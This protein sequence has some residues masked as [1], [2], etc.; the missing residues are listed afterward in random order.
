MITAES[1]GSKEY[2]KRHN[3]NYAYATGGMYRGIASKELVVAM[4]RAGF[5]SYFGSGGLKIS[6]IEEAILE[7]KGR[8]TYD[9]PF[10]INLLHNHIVSENEDRIID[11][12]LKYRVR[13]VEL[14]AFTNITPALVYY[15]LNGICEN[16]NGEIYTPNKICAKLSRLKIAEFF[17]SPPP[18]AI[19]NKL[20]R[21]RKISKKQAEL[22]RLIS[23]AD[24]ICIESD[25]AGHTDR[26]V[27]L[28]MIPAMVRL[29][30]E[31]TEK[32]KYTGKVCIGAAGGVGTPEAAAASFI[33][34]A[35]FIV[36]GS[37]NQ[38][39]VESGAHENVKDLLEKMGVEDTEYCPPGDMLEEGAI[40]QVLK[41]GVLFPARAKKIQHLYKIHN[42]ID[43]IDDETKQHI[44]D[45]YF[46]RSFSDVYEEIKTL[47]S[48]EAIE[49]A[50]R[51]P[52]QK[53]A[54]ILKMYFYDSIRF[55]YSGAR[56]NKVNYQIHT[57]PALGAFNDWVKGTRYEDWR[58][59]NV[60]NIAEMLMAATADF[61]NRRYLNL[62]KGAD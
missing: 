3:V 60:H 36:T 32:Y 55:A 24:D 42:S 53:M 15:K 34:G 13:N 9:Q 17:L 29:R 5:M 49:R 23:V 35:D 50:E 41:K 38:C 61:L 1:L 16:R 30:D 47:F 2:R 43:E 11:L 59:R 28:V 46:N 44:E 58:N 10:G 54:L 62:N 57:S 19:V 12:L 22:S 56:R 6:E 8:L 21:E 31:I 48:R 26:R 18:D 4:A 25:S 45:K 33:M 37:I 40:I 51:D 14:A 39:T 7:I 20:L 27:A 52:K